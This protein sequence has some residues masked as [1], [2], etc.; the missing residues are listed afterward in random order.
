[1]RWV[2]CRARRKQIA[3]HVAARTERLLG[4]VWLIMADAAVFGQMSV[5]SCADSE[6]AGNGHGLPTANMLLPR[7]LL[8]LL[9]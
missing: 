6:S 2:D 1:M 9:W 3:M 8:L 5:Q 4:G 7:S